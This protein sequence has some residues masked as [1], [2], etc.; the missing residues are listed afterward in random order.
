MPDEESNATG[1]FLLQ[2]SP[3]I[4]F[5]G[6]VSFPDIVR[7]TP[8]PCGGGISLPVLTFFP[9]LEIRKHHI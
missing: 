2:V 9:V 4:L 8:I 1:H 5:S 7:E 3:L 6:D